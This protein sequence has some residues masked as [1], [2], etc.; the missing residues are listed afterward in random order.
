MLKLFALAFSLHFEL[1]EVDLF[2]NGF[3]GVSFFFLVLAESYELSLPDGLVPLR[4]LNIL[5]LS[6][7][8]RPDGNFYACLELRF[9]SAVLPKVSADSCLPKESLACLVADIFNPST[10]SLVF[11]IRLL[12][13]N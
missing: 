11:S 10:I 9:D 13:T 4:I 1:F 6:D 12:F 3:P 8:S 2:L 7:L 5:A